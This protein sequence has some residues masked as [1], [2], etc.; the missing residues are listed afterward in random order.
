M[1]IMEFFRVRSAARC[2][3]ESSQPNYSRN[4]LPIA[5]TT[6]PLEWMPTLGQHRHY[7]KYGQIN[8]VQYILI[9]N[10]NPIVDNQKKIIIDL[11]L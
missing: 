10:D 8:P 4:S 1:T 11:F 9:L 5:E 3:F 7:M 2:D 6:K